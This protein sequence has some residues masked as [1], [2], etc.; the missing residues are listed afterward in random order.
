MRILIAEDDRLLGEGLK[1]SL[2]L[3]GY[4]ADWVMDGEEALLALKT[5]HY[6]LLVLDLGLPRRS[7]L[8]VLEQLRA[9]GDA[10]PVL[11]LTA[12]DTPQDRVRGLDAGA[13]DYLIKPF[14]LDELLARL[15]A[16]LRRSQGRAT[17]ILRYEDLTLDPAAHS[18]SQDG[19]PV[20]LSPREFA[21][22][23]QLLDNVGKVQTRGQL[24]ESLY[25]WDVGGVESNAVEVHIHHLRK[26]LSSDL[27]QTVRGVG[28]GIGLGTRR[29]SPPRPEGS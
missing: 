2:S 4:A 12:R 8:A 29:K 24:E 6:A 16:L 23:H 22:L 21:L 1:T 25:A 13:D 28:Y 11:I 14:D 10:L 7:G 20:E 3:A 26:K 5:E 17:P 9:K 19:H 27:I 15:R 18:V